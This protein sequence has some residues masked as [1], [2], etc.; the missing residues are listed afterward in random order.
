MSAQGENSELKREASHEQGENSKREEES[1]VGNSE[2]KN[3]GNDSRDGKKISREPSNDIVSINLKNL[4]ENNHSGDLDK[5]D[6]LQKSLKLNN[7]LTYKLD[8]HNEDMNKTSLKKLFTL[9]KEHKNLNTQLHIFSH[10]VQYKIEPI[11]KKNHDSSS[12]E[13]KIILPKINT[14]ILS[15]NKDEKFSNAFGIDKFIIP[16]PKFKY[17]DTKKKMLKSKEILEENK[18]IRL[19][20]AKEMRE[21]NRLLKENIFILKE[22][23]IEENRQKKKIVDS[24]FEF[25]KSSISNFKLLKQKYIKN[26]LTSDI[27][28]EAKEINK[29][30]NKLETL[31]ELHEK[32][33]NSRQ[34]NEKLNFE[35]IVSEATVPENE[36][37]LKTANS[38]EET[39]ENNDENNKENNDENIIENN[40]ENNENTNINKNDEQQS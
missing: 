33:K 32:N 37:Q 38:E 39:E 36:N 15:Q 3:E 34:K 7:D 9:K 30:L 29:K 8:I 23:V 1:G 21:A 14:R 25:I 12:V 24:R 10:K 17:N 27:E 6:V 22:K 40:E 2:S 31:K 5:G 18:Q 16:N 11:K 19:K 13:R 26:I 35:E 28:R 4:D 20:Q